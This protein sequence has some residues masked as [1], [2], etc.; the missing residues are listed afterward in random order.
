V[1]VFRYANKG[2]LSML[3]PADAEKPVNGSRTTHDDHRGLALLLAQLG[4]SICAETGVR[5]CSRSP[6]FSIV[7]PFRDF[8]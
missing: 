8:P 1:H 7:V 2:A 4:V 5:V 3:L 6:Q